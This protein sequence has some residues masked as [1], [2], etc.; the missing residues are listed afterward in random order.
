MRAR[1]PAIGKTAPSGAILI[2]VLIILLTISLIGATL[3]S[4]FFSVT[5]VA[6][7]ELARAQALYLA[8]AGVAQVV[9][10]IRQAG[11]LGGEAQ[12]TVGPTALGAGSYRAALDVDAGLIT[13]IGTVRGVRRAIQVKYYPF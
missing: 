12:M 3:S 5:T 2:S 7:L 6:E 10:Q 1:N 4:F 9:S 8:E 11:V 13:A